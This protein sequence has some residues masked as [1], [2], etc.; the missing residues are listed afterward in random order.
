M[1]HFLLCCF[2]IIGST[3]VLQQRAFA[4]PP[5]SLYSAFPE[6]FETAVKS[7]YAIGTVSLTSGSWQ[8]DDALIGTTA[9]D[10]KTGHRCVRVRNT[11]RLSL[12]TSLP[13]GIN[14]ISVSHAIYGTDTAAAWELW[15]S[16][17]TGTNWNKIGNTIIT[18]SYTPVTT[19]FTF[20]IVGEVLIELRKV[21]GNRLNFDDILIAM[22]AD[23]SC[24][25]CGVFSDSTPTQDSSLLLGNPSNA[26]VSSTD[27]TNFLIYR[28]QYALSYNNSKG[29]AN[30]VAW[31]LSAAWKGTADRCNCFT[32]DALLPTG[33]FRA[34]T[35]HYTSTGFDRGHVCPSD[36]RDLNDSDNAAT[37]KMTNIQPQAPQLN[38]ITWA[39]L[40]SYCRSLITEGKELYIFSGGYGSGGTGSLGGTTY[41]IGPSG[42]IHVPGHFWKVIVVL[43]VGTNDLSRINATTRVIAVDMPNVQSVTTHPWWYYRTTTDAIEAATGFNFLS[44]VST[45]IQSSLES[46]VDTGPTY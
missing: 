23:A 17:N 43:P 30:W 25:S 46:T 3:F 39:A 29:V 26:T 7:G 27:S 19:T 35:S 20:N 11:G 16:T 45:T 8:L 14:R 5:D 4:A 42:R 6:T 2:S 44:N 33:Y 40:E 13:N 1:R 32:L 37:F 22:N 18:T 9:A 10:H 24:G 38:Q 12:T 15:C 36:D 41:N 28:H 21:G 34:A 31:H